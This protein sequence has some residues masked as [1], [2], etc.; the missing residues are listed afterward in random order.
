MLCLKNSVCRTS[1]TENYTP[2]I[3]GISGF[4]CVDTVFLRHLL[5]KY[6]KKMPINIL[7]YLFPMSN[8]KAI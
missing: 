4:M 7:K 5:K 2:Q 1:Q 6:I 3:F 8:G